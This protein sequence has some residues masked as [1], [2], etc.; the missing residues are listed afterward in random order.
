MSERSVSKRS[1]E[2]RWYTVL[3]P[4][5]FDRAELG[6]T[7]AT[8]P[9]QV[10]DRTIQTTLGDVVEGGENNV[11]LTFQVNDV[12]SDSAY[13][14]FSRYE[15][16]RD[17]KR[18]LVRRGS[19]KVKAVLTLRTTDDYRLTVQPVAYTTKVAD[20]SQKEAIRAKMT[21]LVTE[22]ANERTFEEFLDSIIQ[23]HLSSAIYNEAKTIY[24]LRR[25]EIEKAVLDAKPEEVHAEEETAAVEE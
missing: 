17:Y 1:Q 3:A 2:K 24:P 10:I 21:E 15:L 14:E 6:T 18:S 11:K 8:E 23:G 19:S 7:P 4:E 20:R 12:G 9:E 13:T 22:A 5:Q 25:V 16:T